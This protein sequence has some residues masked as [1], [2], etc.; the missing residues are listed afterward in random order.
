MSIRFILFVV[1][2]TMPILSF[3]QKHD[4]RKF[5]W[6]MNK[7]EVL[8]SEKPRQYIDGSNIGGND[9]AFWLLDQN[10]FGEKCRITYIFCEE[11]K[12]L[13]TVSYSF[14]PDHTYNEYDA[15]QLYTTIYKYIRK[16][17]WLN[18]TSMFAFDDDSID[19]ANEEVSFSNGLENLKMSNISSYLMTSFDSKSYRSVSNILL[20]KFLKGSVFNYKLILE[21]YRTTP[22][23]EHFEC[24]NIIKPKINYEVRDIN[25]AFKE[26]SWGD[27]KEKVNK[28][29]ASPKNLINRSSS[30]TDLMRSLSFLNYD[31]RVFGNIAA[32]LEYRFENNKL[33]EITYTNGTRYTTV[34][35]VLNLYNILDE[36]YSNRTSNGDIEI[37]NFEDQTKLIKKINKYWITTPLHYEWLDFDSNTKISLKYLRSGFCSYCDYRWEIKYEPI[38]IDSSKDL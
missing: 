14:N 36:K 29:E 11:N 23:G 8:L 13:H 37:S 28:S 12:D 27:L 35:D 22:T 3:S 30:N 6:E 9:D 10:E 17:K 33:S 5:R 19:W 21:F 4:F 26:F 7:K 16:K 24:T 25:Y 34:Y 38:K 1:L 2:F 18:E 15:I 32:L 31:V 20:Y